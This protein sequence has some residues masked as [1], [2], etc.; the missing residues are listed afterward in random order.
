MGRSPSPDALPPAEQA[1]AAA[2]ASFLPSPTRLELCGFA[3]P[4]I[5]AFPGLPALPSLNT[6]F[7]FPPAFSFPIPMVCGLVDNIAGNAGYGGGRTPSRVEAIDHEF[8]G[9]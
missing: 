3:L 6:L 7:A 1:A 8:D 9:A 2:N 4:A 5:P